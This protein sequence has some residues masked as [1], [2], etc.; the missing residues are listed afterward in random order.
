LVT[1]RCS[2]Y[3]CASSSD[4]SRDNSSI[5]G[6]STDTTPLAA[7]LELTLGSCALARRHRERRQDGRERSSSE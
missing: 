1:K 4:S 3:L 5:T 7:K 2:Y 6:S